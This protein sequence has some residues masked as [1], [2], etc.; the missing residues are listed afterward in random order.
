MLLSV[1]IK[2]TAFQKDAYHPL[3]DCIQACTDRGVVSQH[4]LGMG[5][6]PAFTGQRVSAR[7][8]V[9]PE[10]VVF[11][12]GVAD[13]PWTEWQ[14]G[15]KTLPCL[16]VAVG[17]NHFRSSI[18]VPLL[19]CG[20]EIWDWVPGTFMMYKLTQWSCDWWMFICTMTSWVS[21]PHY[22]TRCYNFSCFTWARRWRRGT[23][24]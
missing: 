10:G 1:Y 21:L 19:S 8:G 24:W 22:I 3:V 2:A 15:V 20:C 14:T 16:A 4:A 11:P 23:R 6:I 9:C 17:K 13:P 12:G 5:C 7:G 18:N